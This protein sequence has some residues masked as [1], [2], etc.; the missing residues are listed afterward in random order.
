MRESE[1]KAA[2]DQSQP[3][4]APPSAEVE[5]DRERAGCSGAA[6]PSVDPISPSRRRFLGWLSAGLGSLAALLVS[7]PLLGLL[8]SPARRKTPQWREVGG[9]EEFEAG[10]TVLVSYVDPD[11]VPWAGEAGQSTAWLRREGEERFVAFSPY[12]THV[13]CPVTWAAG[14]QLF[15][16]PCHGGTFHSDGRVAAGP[17]P[18]PLERLEVRIRDGRVEIRSHGVPA[19]S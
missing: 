3:A 2:Y 12:C 11:P 7:V 5:A 8:V 4:G 6:D 15:M 10:D 18:R 13:G 19:A 1:E 16:C 9:V 17:P 14:A